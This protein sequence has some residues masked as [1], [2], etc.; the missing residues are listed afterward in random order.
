MLGLFHVELSF[1]GSIGT[2]MDSTGIEDAF[3]EFIAKNSIPQIMNGKNQERSFRS[4]IIA[5]TSLE[6]ILLNRIIYPANAAESADNRYDKRLREDHD[7]ADDPYDD[8]IP[9]LQYSDS[10]TDESRGNEYSD[11]DSE[12]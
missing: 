4:H 11:D 8:Y 9:V 2:I 6:T 7:L 5:G 10:D 3:E 1:L 12:S